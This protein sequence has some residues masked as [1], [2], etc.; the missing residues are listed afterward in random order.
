MAGGGRTF[1]NKRLGGSVQTAFR[2]CLPP[3]SPPGWPPASA[4]RKLSRRAPPYPPASDRRANGR[5]SGKARVRGISAPNEP[6]GAAAGGR[7][8]SPSSRTDKGVTS[9]G[10]AWIAVDACRRLKR[11]PST[12]KRRAPPHGP[13]VTNMRAVTARVTSNSIWLGP[14]DEGRVL[15]LQDARGTARDAVVAGRYRGAMG[16]FVTSRM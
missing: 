12:Q 7:P 16:P 8:G 13:E 10:R 5:N 2:L 15:G 6:A 1:G 9:C 3:A 14:D 4:R 11:P